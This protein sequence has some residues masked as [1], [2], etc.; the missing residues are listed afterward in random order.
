MS[1]MPESLIFNQPPA[2]NW[3]HFLRSYGPSPKN[4]TLFDEYV[5]G[6]LARHKVNPIAVPSPLL[7]TAKKQ[8]DSGSPGSILL[9]GTAGDGKTYHCREIWLH[10]GGSP[11]GWTSSHVMR[12]PLRDGRQAVFVKD[13]SELTESESDKV[14]ELLE[15]SVT[16][17]EKMEFLILASNHGQILDRLRNL[18][19]R[20]KRTHPLR[21]PIQDNFLLQTSAPSGLTIFDLSRV[22]RR[23]SMNAVLKAVAGHP[24]WEKCYQCPLQSAGRICPISE[25]RARALSEQDNGLLAKRLGDIVEVARLNGWHL[26]VRDLLALASNMILGHSNQEYAKEGL[27]T[28]EDIPKIQ[29]DARGGSASI[30]DNVFGANLPHRRAMSR[31][32]FK[33][34][35]AFGIGKETN[36]AVDGLMIFGVEDPKLKEKFHELLGKDNVYGGTEEFLAD[37]KRYLEGEEGARI[38]GGAE[39]FITQLIGQR[40]RLFF[41]LLSGDAEYPFWSLTAFRFAGDFLDTFRLASEKKPISEVVRSRLVRGLNRVMTGLLIENKDKLFVASSGGFSQSRISV[42]CDTEVPSRRVNGVGIQIKLDHLAEKLLMEV[43]L[44]GGSDFS[45]NF[46]LTPVR[47]EF[48][49]RVAE[50]ALPGSF[51]NECLEDMLAFKAKLLR[52]AE[53]LR[54]EQSAFDDEADYS[55][56]TLTLNFIEIEQSGHGFAK[57]ITVR[58]GK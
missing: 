8:I 18:G 34:L 31:P 4:T 12:L 35:A 50:G 1:E 36:N 6:A 51:S 29:A 39:N 42:I 17:Q 58:V 46:T 53:V 10:L 22:A 41:N 7:E 54:Q 2:S 14:L 24:E 3:V 28:C 55:D 38:G 20:Q 47:F 11:K 26:P 23:D 21:K 43:S 16:G 57:P 40:R 30:Y 9:A 49:C 15:L 33:A 5:V 44:A 27:M 19:K 48:L 37:L 45:A 25:N 52:K 56:G 13:L 32:V